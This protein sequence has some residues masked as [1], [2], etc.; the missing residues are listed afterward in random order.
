MNFIGRKW[1][2]QALTHL[3]AKKSA[4]FVVVKGRRRIGKS[5]LI[6]E[7]AKNYTYYSFSGFPPASGI[8]AEFQRRAF[9]LQLEK[10]FHVPVRYESWYELFVFLSEQTKSQNAVILC[11]EISWMGSKDPEFLGALKT[12]WD[13]YFKQNPK[14]ILI[15]CGSVSSWIDDNILAS[16]GFVGRISLTLTVRELSLKESAMFWGDYQA[17][18]S[19]YEQLKVLSVTGGIPRYLEEIDPRMS[20]EDNIKRLCFESSGILYQDFDQIFTDLFSEKASR[21]K[22]II[23][24]LL[25]GSLE[26]EKLIEELDL[27]KNGRVSKELDNLIKSGF[28]QR[29]FAWNIHKNKPPKL[30]VYR[31]SDNYLRFFLKYIDPNRDKIEKGF[32]RE[33][34]LSSFPGWSTLMGLQI[35]NLVLNNRLLIL[36]QLGIPPEIIVNDGA[37]FQRK[38]LRTPGCQIDY[39]IQ[40]KLSELYVIEVKFYKNELNSSVITESKE[41]IK[42]LIRPKNFSIRPILIHVN[43]VNTSVEE[44][45]YFVKI[46]DLSCPFSKNA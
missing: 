33:V 41:K 12:V 34:H 2:L 30:S 23:T 42:R 27:D 9:A 4:S 38:T 37:Y 20:A 35:E 13:Q 5:R 11:D 21:Y 36:E 32:F 6:E 15:V 28:I 39:L 17:S 25:E 29:D 24:T 16:T 46:I 44:S 10:Y 14:M 19:P 22:K 45:D 1:E 31:L 3:K 8:T 40:T 7:F 26:R 43:G 18:S